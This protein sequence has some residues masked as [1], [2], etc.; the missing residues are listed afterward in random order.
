METGD[1]REQS[2]GD[3]QLA[4]NLGF[5][6]RGVVAGRERV[7][8]LKIGANVIGRAPESDVPLS[9]KGVSQRHALLTV[10]PAGVWLN[11]LESKNGSFVNGARVTTVDLR[12]GDELWFG[13]AELSLEPVDSL[14]SE[15][16]VDL[17]PA[18]E[19]SVQEVFEE[20]TPTRRNWLDG[21]LVG[22]WFAALDALLESE[23][24]AGGLESVLVR[25]V[26]RV[27]VRAGA[28]LRLGDR[29]AI[30]LAACGELDAGLEGRIEEWLA[31]SEASGLRFATLA[32][33]QQEPLTM[34]AWSEPDRPAVV[35]VLCGDFPARADSQPLLITLLRLMVRNFVSAEFALPAAL[36][37]LRPELEFPPGY[38]PGIS[39]TIRE[40]HRQMEPLVGRDLPVL[41]NGETGAGKEWIARILHLSSGR[42]RGP[43]VALNCA[44]VPAEL[45][46]AELFGIGERVATGVRARRGRFLQAQGGT[47]LLDEI[48]DLPAALQPKLL[49]ALEAREVHP[50]GGEPVAFDVRII[51]ATNADLLA[52]VD[53]QQFRADLY[54]RLAGVQL[55]VPPLRQR[56]DDIP[57]LVEHFLRQ[58]SQDIGKPIRGLTVKALRRLMAYPWPGNIRELVHEVRR[59]VYVC[60][61]GE[62]IESS[63]LADHIRADSGGPSRPGE[64]PVTASPDS[65]PGE[66]KPELESWLATA[67]DLNLQALECAALAEALRRSGGN[68]VKAGRFLGLSRMAVRRRIDRCRELGHAV[69]D[70]PPDDP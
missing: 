48:G 19:S 4:A 49:R 42:R 10:D 7:F 32:V 47:L 31:S 46:E 1:P 62:A 28:V 43:F 2:D 39:A 23:D 26:S 60:S 38:V 56:R 53:A 5:R 24:Q 13:G 70:A 36:G 50:V 44:A 51:A 61:E 16:A 12:S 54:Y 59:L 63:L 34:A 64:D 69:E 14:D 6:L 18:A 27:G 68:Q 22:R 20:V 40:L 35:L 66:S 55:R 65:S 29:E 17:T 58:I 11:D 41:V 9:V 15:L 25:V 67:D 3:D 21:R 30:V 57:I 33:A 45:L 52:L 8:P 37:Q